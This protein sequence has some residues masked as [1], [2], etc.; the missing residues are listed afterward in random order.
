MNLSVNGGLVRSN[1]SWNL[2]G[3]RDVDRREEDS[4]SLGATHR[5]L[6]R[7]SECVLFSWHL[8]CSL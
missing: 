2:S 5:F 7:N 8:I 1:L 4:S 3:A 6:V